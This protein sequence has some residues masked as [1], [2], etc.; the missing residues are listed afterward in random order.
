M[1]ITN[2]KM[3]AYLF[4][5]AMTSSLPVAARTRD[6]STDEARDLVIKALHSSQRKL[7]GLEASLSSGNQILGFYR[8]EVLWNN[9]N[10]GS[11]V[12]GFFSVNR[13]TG[14][15]WELV[16]CVKQQ[17]RGLSRLQ[18]SLRKTMSLTRHELKENTNEAPCKS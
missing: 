3:Q 8:F 9:P 4:I 17:S 10:E 12:V 7:P 5:I 18:E 11:A 1:T 6:L 2:R 14:D 16:R 13:A 15:V